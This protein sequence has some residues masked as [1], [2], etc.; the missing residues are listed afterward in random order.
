MKYVICLLYLIFISNPCSSST[1]DNSEAL[2]QQANDFFHGYI[3]HLN[4]YL[5]GEDLQAVKN[6]TSQDIRLPSLVIQPNGNLSQFKEQEQVVKGFTAFLE[7]IKAQGV[8][9]IQW[10]KMDLKSINDYAVVANNTAQLI[11]DQ[12]KIIQTIKAVYVL[13]RAENDWAIVL[14]IPQTH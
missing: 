6:K 8:K 9:Q 11:D 4:L 3:N 14:R 1:S 10:Q 12:G 2:R 13:H 5:S 7:Q